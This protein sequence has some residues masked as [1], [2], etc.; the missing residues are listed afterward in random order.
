MLALGFGFWEYWELF[1]KVTFDGVNKLIIVNDG[2]TDLNVQVDIYSDWKEWSKIEDNLKFEQALNAIGGDPITATSN[3][4]ITYFLENGWRM[5]AAEGNYVLSVDGN[6]FTREPGD[7]PFIP[8]TGK[9]SKVTIN[10]VRSNLVDII[11]SQ[12]G[13]EESTQLDELH[14]LSGLDIDNPLVVGSTQ[15]TAGATIDQDI[16]GT[17]PVTVT[18]QP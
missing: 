4:G 6:L 13:T 16:T 8:V 3:V 18:R 9:E 12:L 5:K 1:H 7:D 10:L 11:Q 17:D 15:R 2:V 14:K